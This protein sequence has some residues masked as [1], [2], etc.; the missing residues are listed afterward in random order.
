MHLRPQHI[1]CPIKN[2]NA[3]R[4]QST[5]LGVWRGAG[6]AGDTVSQICLESRRVAQGSECAFGFEPS[7]E[8]GPF[9]RQD[10]SCPSLCSPADGQLRPA[11]S[12]LATY[13]EAVVFPMLQAAAI[14]LTPAPH[15]RRSRTTS[16]IFF[17]SCGLLGTSRSLLRKRSRAMRRDEEILAG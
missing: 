2:S 17:I 12:I 9:R 14:W 15:E 16:S 11:D 3:A 6:A 7:S 1:R 13:S 8:S 4:V 10:I 5:R